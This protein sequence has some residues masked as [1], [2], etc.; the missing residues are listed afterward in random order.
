MT[1]SGTVMNIL[2][3]SDM[4]F[5]RDQYDIDE[6]FSKKK[7]I[8]D[9]LILKLTE[10]DLQFK[11]D[12][13]LVTGDIAW[14]GLKR[15]FDE[16]YDWFSKL[17]SA[18]GLSDDCFVFCPGNHDLNRNVAV[19]FTED[20]LLKNQ[21]K[22][23][24]NIAKCDYY[25]QYEQAQV[26]EN[27]FQDYNR[28]CEKMGMQPYSYN[29]EG[30]REYSYLIGNSSFVYKGCTFRIVCLN[31]AYLPYGNVLSG[32]QMFLGLPQIEQMLQ[33]GIL[34]ERQDDVFRV[35]LFH[36]ADRFLH[37]NEQ[38][39]YDGRKAPMQLLL[40]SV[41][42]A[43][44]GHTETGSMPRLIQYQDGGNLLSG[45]A[46]Y[47]NDDHPNSFS[48]VRVSKNQQPRKISFCFE[49]D[50]WVPY[51]D[52]AAESWEADH[53]QIRWNDAIKSRKKYGF[54][55][56]IDAK[57]KLVDYA[58]YDIIPK[59]TDI[60]NVYFFNNDINPARSLDI[61][62]EDDPDYP[63]R[64]R[65]RFRHGPCQKQMTQSLL[66]MDSIN[67]FLAANLPGAKNASFGLFDLSNGI[68]AFATVP[69][70][71]KMTSEKTRNHRSNERF[72]QRLQE[73]EGF[74]GVLFKVPARDFT[75]TEKDTIDYLYEIREY[76][77]LHLRFPDIPSSDFYVHNPS[78]ISWIYELAKTGQ[79]FA[80]K[81]SRKLMVELFGVGIGL[82]MCTIT[83]KGARPKSV[84]EIEYKIKTWSEGDVRK[85]ATEFPDGM[86]LWISPEKYQ[87]QARETAP[88]ELP[89]A[90][91]PEDAPLTLSED[92]MRIFVEY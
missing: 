79:F 41:D 82:G 46:T 86:D 61:Y 87:G 52:Y 65:V 60:G 62:A 7:E 27:R 32:D 38:C 10:L 92:L 42:L 44:C 69:L 17:K 51:S 31:T 16:A 59:I 81:L 15:E 34:T 64:M 28:L 71:I 11:P 3:L 68:S 91:L 25:Y 40:N 90:V 39:E 83:L 53:D 49:E 14:H 35:A 24:I 23:E 58:Y 54:G 74:Y 56:L 1:E 4:H 76:G 18:L 36:H 78:E 30:I 55:F 43:L 21:G 22:R 57:F 89:M 13:V 88:E 29:C 80:Y 77:N 72:Y 8:L 70:N 20:D 45:G 26:L 6:P 47:Y 37:P 85:I 2:H 50:N 73:L 84:G 67:T 9:K 63:G 33:E 75:K 19:D 48:I 12:L 66:M 5:G